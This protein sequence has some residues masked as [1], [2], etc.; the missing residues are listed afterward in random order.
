MFCVLNYVLLESPTLSM[1][2]VASVPK[3]VQY[4]LIFFNL[5][6]NFRILFE[7]VRKVTNC[8][9]YMYFR[10]VP[11]LWVLYVIVAVQLDYYYYHHSICL[12]RCDHLMCV[13]CCRAFDIF[14]VAS[15][16]P[17]TLTVMVNVYKGDVIT[18]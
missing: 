8:N 18:T 16:L 17:D 10:A 15:P 3:T 2:Y 7:A 6:N 5:K 1:G 12:S 4:I 13:M 11:R 9:I 14:V